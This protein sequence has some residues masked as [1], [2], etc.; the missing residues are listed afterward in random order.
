M[1]RRKFRVV[2]IDVDTHK[3][4]TDLALAANTSRSNYLRELLKREEAAKGKS[5]EAT[6]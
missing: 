4:L 5:L 6:K 3:R 1:V 2:S